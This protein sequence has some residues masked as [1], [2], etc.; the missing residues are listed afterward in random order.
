VKELEVYEVSQFCDEMTF[1]LKDIMLSRDNNFDLLLFDRFFRIL[2][3]AKQLLAINSVDTFVLI[4][5]FMKMIEATNV[6]TIED[7]INQVEKIEPKKEMITEKTT[8]LIENS[9]VKN[10]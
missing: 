1:Y 4:L 9:L 2:S 5:T 10:P 3:D 6:R 8:P 7:I